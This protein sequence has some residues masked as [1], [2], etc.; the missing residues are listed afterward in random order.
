MAS[1]SPD[2]LPVSPNLPHRQR[3]TP[4]SDEERQ[5]QVF[6]AGLKGD[7]DSIEFETALGRA[8]QTSL[9]DN[10]VSHRC[11]SFGVPLNEYQTC[12]HR[13]GRGA[14]ARRLLQ[15]GGHEP[16]T[17]GGIHAFGVVVRVV[18]G[19]SW[20]KRKQ[21]VRSGSRRSRRCAA[22]RWRK[23]FVCSACW[24]QPACQSAAAV[25]SRFPAS[26]LEGLEAQGPDR[27]ASDPSGPFA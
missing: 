8:R 11:S 25:S 10:W 7:S 1:A 23:L 16:R 4:K 3:A 9:F 14:H 21:L 18:V 17:C 26:S 5:L 27:R 12:S 6:H 13:C 20:R 22:R 19:T 15:A 2:A 24:W